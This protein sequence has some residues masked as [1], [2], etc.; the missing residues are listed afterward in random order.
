MFKFTDYV[1]EIWTIARSKQV[2]I[3]VAYDMFRADVVKGEALSYNTGG[4]LSN[5]DFAKTK[6]EWDACTEDERT[7]A[8]EHW[9]DVI[10][11]GDTYKKLASA[12][13]DK[14]K[15]AEVIALT[16]E[17]LSKKEE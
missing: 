8:Y 13:P 14:A 4:A 12:F 2:P 3:D 7:A 11:H 17:N 1:Y 15:M 9:H 10:G 6:A 16:E 5:F